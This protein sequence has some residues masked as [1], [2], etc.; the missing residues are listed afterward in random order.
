LSD[1]R[2]SKKQ[3]LDKLWGQLEMEF[4]SFKPHYQEL[5]DYILPRRGRFYT[6]D[7]NRGDRR[8]KNIIDSTATLAAR[9]LASG[10][11]AG[12]TS[13]ARPWKRLTTPDPDLADVG[14]VKE[15]LDLVDRRMSTVFLRS[16]LYNTLPTL[17][18]DLGIFGTAAMLIEEDFDTVIHT[19]CFP[20]GSYRIAKD[21]KG[22]V[23][24]FA[25]EFQMTV[26]QIVEQFGNRDDKGMIDWSNL[27]EHVKS[28]H[29]SGNYESW[30]T[31]RHF[32][33][34][35]VDYDQKSPFAKNKK[36]ASCYYEVGATD[37]AGNN[38]KTEVNCFLREGGYDYFPVLVPRWETTGED[39]YGTNCPGME[40]LGDIKQL[41]LGEKRSINAID[42]MVKPPMIGHSGLKNQKAS[43]IPGDITYDDAPE[44]KGFR[45]LLNVQPNVKEL[46]YKQD[47]VRNRIRRALF[48][49]LFLMLASSDRR[50]ITAREIEERHEEKL[51]AV[52]PVLE[53]LNQDA[54]DPLIDITFNIMLSQGQIP[55]WPDELQGQDL[56]V[57]YIS[58]MAQAQKSI[59]LAGI[60][61]HTQFVLQLVAAQVPGASEKTNWDEVIEEHGEA[62][63][64]TSKIIRSDD[65]VAA[66]REQQ[67]QAQQQ[68]AQAEMIERGA[69]AAKNLSQ[70]SMSED[71][72]LNALI[73][74][75][76]AGSLVEGA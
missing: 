34:P 32:I 2:E 30:I 31:V 29:K 4:S 39:V 68:A 14:A 63:G 33:C 61:R 9:T 21:H 64:V 56:K 13:P 7:A 11:M 43:I 44:G 62:A 53:Q 15:W 24:V 67:M 66:I 69:V 51:L 75:G 49:D 25:R 38:S 65:E 19:E 6:G 35:N 26:R 71:N 72:A 58:I 54:L 40:A 36:F 10:M 12:I 28:L 20:I 59:A 18:K 47:Q 60:E 76:N 22:K 8:N 16:N 46:E 55:E 74:Q 52:G 23:N 57:E 27:S 42:L 70:T 5:N 41:Q 48:E 37:K 50:N 17:Y 73:G 3:R 1:Q 45:P